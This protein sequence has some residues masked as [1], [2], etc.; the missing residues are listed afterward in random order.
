M[1]IKWQTLSSH[2]PLPMMRRRPYKGIFPP[3][4]TENPSHPQKAIRNSIN[5]G[6]GKMVANTLRKMSHWWSYRK[7]TC[8]SGTCTENAI[9]TAYSMHTQLMQ[10]NSLNS[11]QPA[12]SIRTHNVLLDRRQGCCRWPYIH[13][14]H[15]N[16][17][18][19]SKCEE[20]KSTHC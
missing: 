7:A 5:E 19:I 16:V 6:M 12:H 3:S 9:H 15:K 11:K 1:I 8:T 18:N 17:H 2:V 10:K 4:M 14:F 13:C 20:G